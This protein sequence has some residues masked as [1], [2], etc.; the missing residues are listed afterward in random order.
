MNNIKILIKLH[1]KNLTPRV[2]MIWKLPAVFPG[3]HVTT[4]RELAE[5]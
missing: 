4:E 3:P 1:L 5:A 2:R